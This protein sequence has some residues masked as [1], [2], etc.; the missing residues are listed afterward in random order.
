M[1]APPVD[2]VTAQE[3]DI[4]EMIPLLQHLFSIEADFD[5]QA[6]KAWNGLQLLIREDKCVVLVARLGGRVVGMGS[7][8]QTI[9]TAEGGPALLVEDLV[10]LP[11]HQ[12][13]G[14]GTAL[15]T[16]LT[17]WAKKENI[18]RLQLL[19]DRANGPALAFYRHRGWQQTA[20]VCLRGRSE[21]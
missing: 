4:G 17:R 21:P 9:S 10:V 12:G 14:I 15:L 19:A 7:G 13:K 5:F 6:E 18:G 3:R 1:I 20:L 11:E 2:I 16:G 8:Q